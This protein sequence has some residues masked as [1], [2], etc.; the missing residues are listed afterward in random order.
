MRKMLLAFSLSSVILGS[1]AAWA[2]DK[3]V[4]PATITNPAPAETVDSEKAQAPQVNANAETVPSAQIATVATPEAITTSPA[5]VE[6][7]KEVTLNSGDTAWVLVSTALV[8]LMTIPGLALF[9]GGMVRKKNVLSTMTHSLVAA[10]IVSIVWVVL[11]YSLAFSSTGNAL[12]VDSTKSCSME[13][14]LMD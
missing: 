10:G 13:L 11:G 8:L 12:L 7:V 14:G 6:A 1:S 9:Y 3:I 4:E 5:P 2:E